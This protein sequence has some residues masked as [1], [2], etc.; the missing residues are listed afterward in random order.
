MAT[1]HPPVR[2][3]LRVDARSID[4]REHLVNPPASTAMAG[5]GMHTLVMVPAI[6]N[7]LRPVAFTAKSRNRGLFGTARTSTRR[8]PTILQLLPLQATV[9]EFRSFT[10]SFTPRKPCWR[11]KTF[12]NLRTRTADSALFQ[13]AEKLSKD[14]EN[15]GRDA[16]LRGSTFHEDI[17]ASMRGCRE[18]V[19][20]VSRSMFP[21]ARPVRRGLLGIAPSRRNS[22]FGHPLLPHRVSTTRR[23]R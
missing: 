22:Q 10:R 7:C 8:P 11:S 2:V 21:S 23:R 19:M 12:V 16:N 5:N 18:G 1:K 3:F 6:I 13:T 17:T 4:H 9:S 20:L 14:A 15:A